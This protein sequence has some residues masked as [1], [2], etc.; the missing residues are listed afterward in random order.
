MNRLAAS[1]RTPSFEEQTLS[2][3]KVPRRIAAAENISE[4]STK[5]QP[6]TI[7]IT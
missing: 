7:E 6:A 4:V 1:D 2:R 5:L 3:I